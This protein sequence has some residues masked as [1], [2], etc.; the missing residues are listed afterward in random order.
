MAF[1]QAQARPE[2]LH[3]LNILVPVDPRHTVEEWN[4]IMGA[5]TPS[6]IYLPGFSTGIKPQKGEIYLWII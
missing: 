4:T 2:D 6:P 5:R 1:E 3:S